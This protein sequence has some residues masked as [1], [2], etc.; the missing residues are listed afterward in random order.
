MPKQSKSFQTLHTLHELKAK[1]HGFKI[2]GFVS[3]VPSIGLEYPDGS[4]HSKIIHPDGTE[5]VLVTTIKK[6]SENPQGKAIHDMKIQNNVNESKTHPD[7]VALLKK[8]HDHAHQ[9]TRDVAHDLADGGFTSAREERSAR[10]GHVADALRQEFHKHPHYKSGDA[11]PIARKVS[12]GY[13]TLG[14]YEKAKRDI[15][16]ERRREKAKAKPPKEPKPYKTPEELETQKNAAR[17]KKAGYPTTTG[18]KMVKAVSTI[19]ENQDSSKEEALRVHHAYYKKV[20]GTEHSGEPYHP[21]KNPNGHR[22]KKFHDGTWHV[23]SYHEGED[24]GEPVTNEVTTMS[25]GDKHHGKI[26][27]DIDNNDYST[28]GFKKIAENVSF[29]EPVNTIFGSNPFRAYKKSIQE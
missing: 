4:V 15:A 27:H 26:D 29:N 12:N 22:V 19:K 10:A 23:T 5:G 28:R 6:D 1:A 20:T 2:S 14:D 21:T 11:E 9:V 18:K 24:E 16:A 8:M 13:E 7:R 17:E 25:D 3:H